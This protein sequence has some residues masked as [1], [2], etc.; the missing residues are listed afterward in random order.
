MQYRMTLIGCSAL[1]SWLVLM[2]GNDAAGSPYDAIA[3]SNVFH[4]VAPPK[5]IPPPAV[6]PT[7]RLVGIATV[8]DK[9]TAVLD[10][11]A[12][13]DGTGPREHRSIVLKEGETD[14]ELQLI[15]IDEQTNT[16]TVWLSGS[17]AFLSFRTELRGSR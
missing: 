17:L 6:R 2:T 4:L 10:I 15:A 1:I 16:V 5:P 7:I 8:L 11:R 3:R 12:P 14:G 9:K 13:A